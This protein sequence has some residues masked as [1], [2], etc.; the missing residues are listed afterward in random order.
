MNDLNADDPIYNNLNNVDTILNKK[1]QIRPLYNYFPKVL[2][3]HETF[4]QRENQ[5]ET[6]C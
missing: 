2:Y 3:V 6:L 4:R 1:Q 5:I